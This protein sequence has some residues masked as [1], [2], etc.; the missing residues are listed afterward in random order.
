MEGRFTPFCSE[1]EIPQWMQPGGA[2]REHYVNGFIRT[3]EKRQSETNM[4]VR[5]DG[6]SSKLFR[7]APTYAE[8]RFGRE[9]FQ[10]LSFDKY[11]P[12]DKHDHFRHPNFPPEDH[13]YVNLPKDCVYFGKL[14]QINSSA[15]RISQ[16]PHFTPETSAEAFDEHHNR[17]YPRVK[18]HLY[19]FLNT[20]VNTS[21]STSENTG[22]NWRSN[23]R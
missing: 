22:I 20:Q 23:V 14:I 9:C 17:V 21:G 18:T 5:E 15:L 4:L 3:E 11:S 13:F 1:G 8:L 12:R 7:F 16:A 10:V 2:A 19:P 6:S